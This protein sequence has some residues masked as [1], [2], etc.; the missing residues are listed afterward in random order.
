MR[1]A[2]DLGYTCYLLADGTGDCDDLDHVD[3]LRMAAEK[4]GCR[5][6]VLDVET[7][8][9]ALGWYYDVKGPAD[10]AAVTS[11]Q[12]SPSKSTVLSPQPNQLAAV[13]TST[14]W[15]TDTSSNW[16]VLAITADK[17]KH[18]AQARRADNKKGNIV[19]R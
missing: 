4:K 17:Q 10:V 6:G 16:A 14:K 13:D 15:S 8:L 9:K 11:S 2:T 5:G 12:P 19:L 3:T 7:L 18:S 1:E